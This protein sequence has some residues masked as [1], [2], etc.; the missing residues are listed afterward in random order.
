[1]LP[2]NACHL[3]LDSECLSLACRCLAPDASR[4]AVPHTLCCWPRAPP[5]YP[6]RPQELHPELLQDLVL[7][8]C[9]NSKAFLIET[10][11]D[12]VSFVGNRTECALLVL[13]RKW[14]VD[15][16][17]AS[18]RLMQGGVVSRRGYGALWVWESVHSEKTKLM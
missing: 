4:P 14:G 16:K 18:S 11:P 13:T 7:N 3:P 12:L 1:M 9:L 5:P 6:A 15:Y 10:A 8:C 2:L 17:Q